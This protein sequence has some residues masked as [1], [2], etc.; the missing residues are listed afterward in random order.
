MIAAVGALA[1]TVVTLI[2]IPGPSIL[3]IVGQTLAAGKATAFR[4]VLGNALGTLT[5][6]ILITTFLGVAIQQS[7]VVQTA[8]RT[9]GAVVLVLLGLSFLLAAFR[10]RK[11][12]EPSLPEAAGSARPLATGWLV[13]AT[14]PKAMVIFGTITPSFLPAGTAVFPGLTVLAFVPVLVGFFVDSLWLE[15]A[16]RM[17][18][19]LARTNGSIASINAAGG[20]LMIVMAALIFRGV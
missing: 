1:A 3:Y 6:G 9:V 4:S 12:A 17:K 11:L 14:N 19:W 10:K 20:I 18:G 8:L 2:A 7:S 16:H 15:G 5:A 13:G